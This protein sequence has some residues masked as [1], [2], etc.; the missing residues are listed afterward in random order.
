MRIKELFAVPAGAKVTEKMFAKVLIS[1]VC[2]IL[3]CMTC[4]VGTT[5]AWFTVS[6][7]NTGNVLQIGTAEVKVTVDGSTV[8]IENSNSPDDLNKKAAVYVTFLFK[9]KAVGYTVLD[10]NNRYQ[11]TLTLEGALEDPSLLTWTASWY[12]PEDQTIQELTGNILPLTE[13]TA[14]YTEDTAAPA[15]ETEATD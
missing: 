5:W 7:E 14:E 8:S 1:S 2:S 9:E 13:E 11:T 6:I 12:P 4:L 3:L 15:A 10:S